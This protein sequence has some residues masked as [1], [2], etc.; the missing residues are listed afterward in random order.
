MSSSF[1]TCSTELLEKARDI[2]AEVNKIA[3]KDI[4]KII[5]IHS[6]NPDKI[7]VLGLG[8]KSNPST[9]DTRDSH[10][11]EIA[12]TLIEEDYQI[13]YYDPLID[14]NGKNLLKNRDIKDIEQANF[15]LIIFPIIPSWALKKIHNPRFKI[16]HAIRYWLYK[17]KTLPKNGKDYFFGD[18]SNF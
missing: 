13:S 15:D 1:A 8:F 10:S 9:G 11:L 17:S 14:T 16:N 3:I 6:I 4:K 18:Y 5:D 7:L 2:N 12:L